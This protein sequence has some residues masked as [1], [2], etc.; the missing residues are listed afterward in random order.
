M[1][2]LKRYRYKGNRSSFLKMLKQSSYNSSLIIQITAIF[3]M[4]VNF[5]ENNSKYSVETHRKR[6]YHQWTTMQAALYSIY[7]VACTCSAIS[8]S[9][10]EK[11]R[12][13]RA[14]VRGS[15]PYRNIWRHPIRIFG[16][17]TRHFQFS[18]SS[19]VFS[20][21]VRLASF[22]SFSNFFIPNI[23]FSADILYYFPSFPVFNAKCRW[24]QKYF[25]KFIVIES[26]DMI[27][28]CLLTLRRWFLF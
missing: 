17:A 8:K 19:L 3:R 15:W 25:I 28:N 12:R 11:Q 10:E 27:N 13:A 16:T 14:E 23:S 1:R 7:S 21:S 22:L 4:S 6:L 20:R 9:C 26:W 18:M 2:D 24:M 5:A